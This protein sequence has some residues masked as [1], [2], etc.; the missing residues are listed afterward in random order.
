M[1]KGCSRGRPWVIETT[2]RTRP[3][4]VARHLIFAWCTLLMC[5][6][7]LDAED[8]NYKTQTIH[9]HHQ[10]SYSLEQSIAAQAIE[11]QSLKSLILEL[12]DITKNQ[13]TSGAC[14]HQHLPTSSVLKS[15][16]GQGQA[17]P[18]RAKPLPSNFT[19]EIVKIFTKVRVI[20][21]NLPCSHW[22]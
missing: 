14:L 4:L 19:A 13:K 15:S 22:R 10:G 20:S 9:R 8:G 7:T 2:R 17:N 3:V 21:K 12:S 6:A 11:I 5:E 18:R 1:N 16:I